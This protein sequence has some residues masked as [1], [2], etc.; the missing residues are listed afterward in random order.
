MK[1]FII[2]VFAIC[3]AIA[4]ISCSKEAQ[5]SKGIVGEW[6]YSMLVNGAIQ[7]YYEITKDGRFIKHQV[8]PIGF[9]KNN[10]LLVATNTDFTVTEEHK[11]EFKDDIIF[12]DGKAEYTVKTVSKD[13]LI[14]TPSNGWGS[15]T[16]Y[17][18]KSKS[19]DKNSILSVLPNDVSSSPTSHDSRNAILKEVE[20]YRNGNLYKKNSISQSQIKDYCFRSSEYGIHPYMIKATVMLGYYLWVQIYKDGDG[21]YSSGDY[22]FDLYDSF[23][24]Q[25]F[26]HHEDCKDN[27]SVVDG[28]LVHEFDYNG[29]KYRYIYY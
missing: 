1:K 3:L 10:V 20:I 12:L 28:K 25:D 27:F 21:Y 18:V 5:A 9:V 6:A 24:W 2:L 7:N 11:Y 4:S 22:S 19:T 14:I 26:C 17:R 15:A 23:D 13:E 8:C 29:D 16:C